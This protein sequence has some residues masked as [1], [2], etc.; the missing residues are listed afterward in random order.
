MLNGCMKKKHLQGTGQE[1]MHT[2]LGKRNVLF[3]TTLKQCIKIQKVSCKRVIKM[4]Y[5]MDDNL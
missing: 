1:Q 3:H 4:I 5:E 2:V